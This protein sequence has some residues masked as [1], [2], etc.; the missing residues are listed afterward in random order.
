MEIKSRMYLA[1][2]QSEILC[3][4]VWLVGW[5]LIHMKMYVFLKKSYKKYVSKK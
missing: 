3:E 4:I 1:G 5:I 2:I